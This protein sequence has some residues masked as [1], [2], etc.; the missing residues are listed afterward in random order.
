MTIYVYDILQH[1]ELQ[2]LSTAAE[3]NHQQLPLCC[4][5]IIYRLYFLED[6]EYTRCVRAYPKITMENIV[7]FGSMYGIIY[8]FYFHLPRKYI[9][10]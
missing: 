3:N 10:G 2:L 5:R 7:Q 4:Y 8:L 1:G 6:D 9:T